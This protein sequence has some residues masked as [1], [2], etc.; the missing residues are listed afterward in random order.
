MLR[1]YATNLQENVHAEERFQ[2]SYFAT[3]LKSC[4]LA[5]VF[6]CQFVTYFQNTFL[7][8][9]LR[10]AAHNGHLLA[11]EMVS[12]KRERVLVFAKLFLAYNFF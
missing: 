10:R 11:E 7:L 12:Q 4:A 5:W 8:E 2:E 6:S 9:D 1:E 3:L